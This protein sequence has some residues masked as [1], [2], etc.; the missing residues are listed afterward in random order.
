LEDPSGG[1]SS[2]SVC[3]LIVPSLCFPMV[4]GIPFLVHNFLVTNYSSRIVMD[5][6]SGFDLMNPFLPCPR[7]LVS[8]PVQRYRKIV[9]T[10]ENTLELKKTV[11]IE[12]R[13]YIHDHPELLVSDPVHPIDVAAAVCARVE[14]L[15]D[16]ECLLK[17]GDDIKNHFADV[18][19]DIPHME[20]LPTNITCNIS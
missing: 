12:L 6:T 13:G 11:L 14:K 3:T 17:L 15:S 8:S 7:P 16:L 19:G 4:L 2:C 5:K 10:Y 1:W 9:A 20:E 18:F